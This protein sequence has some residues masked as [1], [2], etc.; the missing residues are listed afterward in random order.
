[1]CDDPSVQL[2]MAHMTKKQIKLLAEHFNVST[3]GSKVKVAQR[4]ASAQA[5]RDR[6]IFNGTAGIVIRTSKCCTELRR[7]R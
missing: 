1:M 6:E 4:V 3:E 2:L 7:S 5:E